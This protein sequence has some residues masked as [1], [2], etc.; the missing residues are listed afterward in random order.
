MKMR[1]L[2]SVTLVLLSACTEESAPRETALVGQPTSIFPAGPAT[3]RLTSLAARP[4]IRL[5]GLIGDL[6]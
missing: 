3:S 1:S 2:L 5:A 4:T 6:R